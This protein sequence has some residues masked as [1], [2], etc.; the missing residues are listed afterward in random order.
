MNPRSRLVLVGDYKIFEYKKEDLT[1]HELEGRG[2]VICQTFLFG[3]NENETSSLLVVD[4][5][6][7]HRGSGSNHLA[8]WH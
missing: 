7:I 2:C 1:V 4:D 6:S 3:K 8:V 5:Y